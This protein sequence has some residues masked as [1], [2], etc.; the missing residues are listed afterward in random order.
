[1]GP[2]PLD[3]PVAEFRDATPS[4]FGGRGA[5]QGDDI[6]SLSA[7]LQ[8]VKRGGKRG[9]QQDVQALHRARAQLVNHRTGLST[10]KRRFAAE[11]PGIL[12]LQGFT[13]FWNK[14]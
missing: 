11:A 10:L 9:E 2:F 6:A 3:D 8:R 5:A 13:D 12:P 1:M 14:E 7:G 4:C